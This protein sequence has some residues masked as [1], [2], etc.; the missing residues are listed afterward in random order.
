MLDI[1]G[2]FFLYAGSFNSGLSSFRQNPYAYEPIQ[3]SSSLGHF[4]P[5]G[6]DIC[7]GTGGTIT[8][9]RYIGVFFMGVNPGERGIGSGIRT[10]YYQR[11]TS[12]W[13]LNG[14][15]LYLF[16][17]IKL[18]HGLIFSFTCL[19]ADDSGAVPWAITKSY[20]TGRSLSVSIIFNYLNLRMYV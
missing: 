7:K 13:T 20:T 9:T 6:E 3:V 2:S 10:C 5:R 16:D 14:A 8:S 15:R 19:S 17:C 12:I 11:S 18:H 4:F 1:W